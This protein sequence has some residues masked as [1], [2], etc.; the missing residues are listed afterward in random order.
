MGFF[1]SKIGGFT[2]SLLDPL[3]GCAIYPVCRA[4]K[5][6][7]I[8]V[9]PTGGKRKNPD[10]EFMLLHGRELLQIPLAVRG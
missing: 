8:T 10:L 9:V 3:W 2:S 6:T 5:G 1:A 7:T 4:K